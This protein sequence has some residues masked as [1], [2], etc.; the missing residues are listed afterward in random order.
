MTPDDA[1][2]RSRL[3]SG[4]LTPDGIKTPRQESFIVDDPIAEVLSVFNSD[5][6][7]KHSDSET[8]MEHRVSFELTGEDV[9]RCLESKSSSSFREFP[10]DFVDERRTTGMDR[11]RCEFCLK[12]STDLKMGSEICCQKHHLVKFGSGKEFKFDSA[13]SNGDFSSKNRTGS[14]WSFFPLLQPEVS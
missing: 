3:G 12:E 10:E 8:V 13:S 1:G 2:F 5:N 6:G 4:C 9:A 14:S 7:S 11:N